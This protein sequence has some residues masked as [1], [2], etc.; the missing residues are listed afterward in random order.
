MFTDKNEWVVKIKQR[1][2]R[3]KLSLRTIIVIRKMFFRL[4]TSVGQWK[5][6]SPYKE[7]NLRPSDLRSDVRKVWGSIP[8]GDSE[9][10]LFSSRKIIFNSLL[11]SKLTISIISII[12]IV[13]DHKL[14][15]LFFPFFFLISFTLVVII[16]M[17]IIVILLFTFFSLDSLRA[18]ISL[19]ALLSRS[20]WRSHNSSRSL[21]TSNSFG[22]PLSGKTTSSYWSVGPCHTNPVWTLTD[23][24]F[25]S[26]SHIS[27]D[28]RSEVIEAN[29]F[30]AVDS[31][32]AATNNWNFV[33]D[34]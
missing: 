24:S 3:T 16:V 5:I 8:H 9:F 21:F 27:L 17:I 19:D 14:F 26:R 7:S 12:V 6:L 4:V 31:I 22:P 30:I 29:R 25:H 20:S 32:H 13:F 1:F 33:L 10:F 34:G 23:I 28:S 2:I 18:N 15:I 11:S